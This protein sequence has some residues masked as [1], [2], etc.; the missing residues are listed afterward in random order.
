MADRKTPPP[1]DDGWRDIH[2]D[3]IIKGVG[4]FISLVSD[5]VEA[6]NNNRGTR[7]R[8]L[9]RNEQPAPA[10]LSA[11]SALAGMRDPIVDLFDEDEEIIL[12]VE[13]PYVDEGPIKVELQDDVL[14]L[15]IAG[16]RPYTAELLLPG[17]VDAATLRQTYHNGMTEVRLRRAS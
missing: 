15:T 9:G 7:A 13:W 1:A 14:A 16:E 8:P 11:G 4:T 12:V 2:L 6:V 3:D 17:A 5:V 10:R